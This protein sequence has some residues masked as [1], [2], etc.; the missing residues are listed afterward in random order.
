MM[1]EVLIAASIISV[2]VLVAMSVAQKSIYVSRQSFHTTQ[3]SFLLEE[4][5]EA[6]R[7]SRD[8]AW[9]NISGLTNNVNYYPKFS[10]GTWSLTTNSTDG[11]VG[12]F[13]RTIR[14]ADVNRDN[15]TKDIVAS[16]GTVDTGTRLVTISVSWIEGGRTVTKTLKFYIADIFS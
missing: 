9:S 13:T 12:I 5:A 1:V 16:G 10:N 11:I 3:S 14:V 6:I 8:N 7:I 4:G 2:S 15:T